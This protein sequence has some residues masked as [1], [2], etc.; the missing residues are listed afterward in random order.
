MSLDA[1]S[2][3]EQM[4]MFEEADIGLKWQWFTDLEVND[5]DSEHVS[6]LYLAKIDISAAQTEE[7]QI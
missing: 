3:K 7:A 5:K 6:G 1:I 4:E 2:F